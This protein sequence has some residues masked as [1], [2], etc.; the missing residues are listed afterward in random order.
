ME[1]I[2]RQFSKD[3]EFTGSCD[4]QINTQSR[5]LDNL[6]RK[7]FGVGGTL[8]MNPGPPEKHAPGA[9]MIRGSDLRFPAVRG[10]MEGIEEKTAVIQLNDAQKK[11]I[12]E[13]TGWAP[14]RVE[15]SVNTSERSRDIPLT[16]EQQKAI[17]DALG[18]RMASLSV[19]REPIEITLK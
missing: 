8:L 2:G 18:I 17:D 5:L 15:V 16:D 12:Q 4:S 1:K 3:V 6:Q 14:S 9:E 11:A 10:Y 19:S 7:G 13:V